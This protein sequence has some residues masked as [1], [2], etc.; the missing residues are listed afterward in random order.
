MRGKLH[1]GFRNWMLNTPAGIAITF[2]II[3]VLGFWVF[4]LVFHTRTFLTNYRREM[5]WTAIPGLCLTI[6]IYV[7][8]KRKEGSG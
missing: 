1:Q 3:G 7:L 4:R 8:V 2:F 5:L 6:A